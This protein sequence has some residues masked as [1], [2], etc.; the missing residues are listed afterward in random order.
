MIGANR[1][2]RCPVCA[3][4]SESRTVAGLLQTISRYTGM[5]AL[6]PAGMGL[7]SMPI[8]IWFD[9]FQAVWAFGLMAIA[10]LA[11]GGSLDAFGI[12]RVLYNHYQIFWITACSWALVCLLGSIP[13]LYEAAQAGPGE[14]ESIFASFYNAQFESVPGF[15]TTGLTMVAGPEHRL[16]ASIQCWR[17]SS[18]W[19][20]DI[21]IIV[22]DDPR[23]VDFCRASESVSI[24]VPIDTRPSSAVMVR[25]PSGA[26]RRAACI[27]QLDARRQH[28]M[29]GY[30][31]SGRHVANDHRLQHT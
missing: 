7:I 16:Q 18:Q 9:E 19:V 10:S 4:R 17:S 30:R 8:A 24:P 13:Y 14:L 23:C 15:T 21:G 26:D 6:I 11:V 12:K 20:G 5:T 3:T 1:L 31:L 28:S 25:L 22:A 27:R 29:D 2:P